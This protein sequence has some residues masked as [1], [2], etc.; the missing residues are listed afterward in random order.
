VGPFATNSTVPVTQLA[1]EKYQE[2]AEDLAAHAV[3]N[4]EGLVPCELSEG[5]AAC[6]EA[7]I[8]AFGKRAYRRPLGAEERAEL[9]SVFNLGA[10]S[11]GFETGIRLVI[12]AALQSPYF[13]YM[14]ELG[15]GSQG[16][17]IPL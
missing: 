12:Q 13:L 8:D 11:Q 4:L 14:I 17:T 15:D 6:A 1:I 16:D 2:A 10:Q 9:L 7:F 3:E 5:D